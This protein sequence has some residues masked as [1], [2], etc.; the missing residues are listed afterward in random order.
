MMTKN[1]F[2]VQDLLPLYHEDLLSNET[3]IWMK[4][5]LE[6]CSQCREL[7]EQTE[8]PMIEEKITSPI[9]HEK[10]MTK[11]N[12]K[13]SLYQIIFI[14]ISFFL[15]LN[16]ALL[17]DSFG[18]ILSYAVLGLVIYLFYK[19]FL[20]TSV[21]AFLPIFIWSL[22]TTMPLGENEG[23]NSLFNQLV[24]SFSGSILLAAIHLAFALIGALISW[25]A[26]KIKE[27]RDST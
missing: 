12:L 16:T 27:G 22:S 25:L 11:I 17:N 8:I 14:G 1:C 10:M 19:S 15:A 5:H 21:I 7:E 3:R 23:S 24:Q 4:D 2:I 18:F 20:L 26:L 6:N 13:I 9:N